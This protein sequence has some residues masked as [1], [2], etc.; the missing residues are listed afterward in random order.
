MSAGIDLV[1][2][3]SFFRT[4]ICD[5]SCHL[6]TELLLSVSLIGCGGF[7]A[8][9]LGTHP[10]SSPMSTGGSF[11]GGKSSGGM[12]LNCHLHL[13]LRLMLKELYPHFLIH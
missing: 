6:Q 13:V 11:P 5:T 9:T 1:L 2:V 8:D 12:K 7:I 10:A 4:L 3:Y